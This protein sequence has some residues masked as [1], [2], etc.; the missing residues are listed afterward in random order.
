MRLTLRVSAGRIVS[1]VERE[2]QGK[3]PCKVLAGKYKA[4]GSSDREVFS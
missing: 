1:D 4:R 2:I 3:I